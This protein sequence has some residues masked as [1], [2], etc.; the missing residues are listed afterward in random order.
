MGRVD[1]AVVATAAERDGEKND[2][3]ELENEE[4][5]LNES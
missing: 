1:W 2:E 4:F 5:K 3:E